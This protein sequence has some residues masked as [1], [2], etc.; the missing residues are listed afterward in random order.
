VKRASACAKINLALLV[1]PRRDDGLHEVVTVLQ[2]IDLADRLEL[3][4]AHENSVSGFAEDTLVKRALDLVSAD[5]NEHWRAKLEKRIPVSAGLG[6]GSSHAATAL[7]LAGEALTRGRLR[8]LAGALGADVPFFLASGP[9]LATGDGREL[10]PL[11]LPQDFWIVLVLPQ[12][13]QKTSTA[14]I[15]AAFD[16][17]GDFEARRKELLDT[18]TGVRRASDLAALPPNDLASSSVAEELRT[19][20]AFRAD[21]SGAGPAVYGLFVRERDARAA[22]DVLAHRGRVWVTAPAWYG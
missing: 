14:A 13:A 19:A 21:V 1:G 2:R 5:T 6:G 18:L 8:D 7:E 17:D 12:G 16:D 11:E 15:Y 10:E 3:E 9:Q 4:S 20:G 22:A